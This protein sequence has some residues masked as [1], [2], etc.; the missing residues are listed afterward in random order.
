[1]CFVQNIIFCFIGSQ[2]VLQ[3]EI[4]VYKDTIGGN[5]CHFAMG[6]FICLFLFVQYSLVKALSLM[7]DILFYDTSHVRLGQGHQNHFC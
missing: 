4:T 7:V 2:G 6:V 5:S 1:M 3:E